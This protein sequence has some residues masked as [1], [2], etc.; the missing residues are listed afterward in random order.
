MRVAFG[1]R[2]AGLRYAE[3]IRLITE[4]GLAT[5]RSGEWQRPCTR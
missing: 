4:G 2:A 3:R 1:H 5:A